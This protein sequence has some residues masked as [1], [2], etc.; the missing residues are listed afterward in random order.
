VW[1]HGTDADL[2]AYTTTLADLRLAPGQR[3]AY[4][5]REDRLRL[6]VEARGSVSRIHSP[7][8]D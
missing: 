5:D 6:T 7:A 2:L 1:E 4:V 8:V 3:L